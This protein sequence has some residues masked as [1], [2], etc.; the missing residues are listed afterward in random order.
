MAM[1]EPYGGNQNI[2]MLV[3]QLNSPPDSYGDQSPK[4]NWPGGIATM[5]PIY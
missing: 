5:Q 1:P 3:P 4:H 2:K